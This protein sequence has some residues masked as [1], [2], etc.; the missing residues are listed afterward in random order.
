VAFK[1]IDF[2]RR[3]TV[4]AHAKVIFALG[5]TAGCFACVA[6]DAFL[7]AVLLGPNTFNDSFITV[8]IEQIHV[9]TPHEI[10]VFDALLTFNR[11]GD[12]G[13]GCNTRLGRGR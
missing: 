7:E 11:L 6:V 13:L 3:V 10:G 2:H 9:I 5:H 4:T 8:M 12:H 1:A